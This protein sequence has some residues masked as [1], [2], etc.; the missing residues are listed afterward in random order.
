MARRIS[1]SQLKSQL[2][3]AQSKQ[4]QAINKYNQKVRKVN[5]AINQYNSKARA[6]N[7]R[8]RA[9]Q[10]RLKSELNRLSSRSTSTRT[11][12]YRVSVRTVLDA[13]TRYESQVGPE[14][15]DPRHAE[16]LDLAERESANSAAVANALLDEQATDEPTVDPQQTEIED[17]LRSIS[18]DLDQRWRGAV[19]SLSPENPD[20]ARHFCTS[21]REV[22]TQ[23]LEATAPDGDVTSG[24]PACERTQSGKPTRRSKI[25]H[26]LR[27]KGVEVE[28]LE[29]FVQTDIDNII[30][31]FN[32]LNSGTHG[33]A[34]RFDLRQLAAIKTRA[35][36]G[37]LFLASI[38]S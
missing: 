24:D 36:H 3:Q 13:Y 12:T 8:V 19:F 26:V 25:R 17:Q 4:Q 6:H 2:R 32:E 5:S 7:A 34:G 33:H 9:N 1:I 30:E 38:V 11:V 20:A 16:W 31:L 10:Q 18:P 37:I 14:P 15:A 35:E 29:E 27:R 28:S 23:I 22:F 21:T